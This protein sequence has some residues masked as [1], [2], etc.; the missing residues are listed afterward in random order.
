MSAR[1]T[2]VQFAAEQVGKPY[3]WGATGPNGYD[4]SGLVYA[5]LKAA[6]VET[7]RLTAAGFGRMGTAVS[8]TDAKP[9]DLVYYDE[10][11]AVDH[12]GIYVGNHKMIDAPTQGKNV[13]VTDIG[14][15]TS[16][17]NVVSGNASPGAVAGAL[18]GAGFGAGAGLPWGASSG[19]KGGAKAGEAASKLLPNWPNDVMTIALKV[20]AG[21]AVAGLA[22][23]GVKQAVT[24]N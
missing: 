16:I 1:D 12:V 13:E 18:L 21:L 11:G 7:K 10:P 15:P 14:N 23:V 17:R 2:E 22:V 4:C 20:T 9:G 24:P 3:V 6:G 5:A 8:I 19:A